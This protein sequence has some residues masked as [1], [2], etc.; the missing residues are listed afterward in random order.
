MAAS[1]VIEGL[2]EAMKRMDP[3]VLKEPLLRFL[4]VVG[5]RVVEATREKAPR[6]TGRLHDSI[7]RTLDR[8]TPP[9]WVRIESK[10]KGFP[11]PDRLDTSAAM[12]YAGGPLKGRQTQGWFSKTAEKTVQELGSHVDD[13]EREI[14]RLMEG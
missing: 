9:K 13:L 3:G 8:A 6:K 7:A 2:E 1:I 14:T 10:V 12:H 4:D 5:K 11:Y